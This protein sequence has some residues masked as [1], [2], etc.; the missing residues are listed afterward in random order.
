[1]LA[2]IDSSSLVVSGMLAAQW[3]ELSMTGLGVTNALSC[4]LATASSD[5]GIARVHAQSGARP[6]VAAHGIPILGI[7]AH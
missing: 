3:L 1:M 6:R 4:T 5:L 7:V 2:D